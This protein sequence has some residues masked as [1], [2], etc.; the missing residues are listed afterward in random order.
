MTAD[1]RPETAPF[2]YARERDV[3]YVDADDESWDIRDYMRISGRIVR[4]RH[5]SEAAEYRLFA[6]V[7]GPCRLYAF[8]PSEPRHPDPALLAR[9]FGRAL[10][11]RRATTEALQDE[12]LLQFVPAAHD[13]ASVA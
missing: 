11:T 13:D 5:Q 9:Q 3:I 8:A 7:D 12:P 2:V 6:P 4:L 10:P 1:G